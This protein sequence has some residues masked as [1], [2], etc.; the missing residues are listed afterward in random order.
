MATSFIAAAIGRC[1][2]CGTRR[3]SRR[4]SQQSAATAG[5]SAA[6]T[7]STASATASA[8][9]TD[10]RVARVA[11]GGCFRFVTQLA[12]DRKS[13]PCHKFPHLRPSSSVLFIIR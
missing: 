5:A 11:L 12:I 1:S 3:R 13:V 2:R 4:R 7:S 8:A 10:E 6:T 9:A